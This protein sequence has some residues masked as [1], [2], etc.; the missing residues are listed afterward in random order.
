MEGKQPF[1]D[2][3]RPRQRKTRARGLRSVSYN[4]QIPGSYLLVATCEVANANY[5]TPI[6]LTS[7][8]VLRHNTQRSSL[9]KR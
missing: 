3:K 4:F 2:A 1:A 9:A 7:D 8:L 6:L 5:L